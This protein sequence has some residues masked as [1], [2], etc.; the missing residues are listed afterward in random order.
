MADPVRASICHHGEGMQDQ[1]EPGPQTAAE[2]D[3]KLQQNNN[4]KR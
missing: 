3:W 4:H 2:L 1:H